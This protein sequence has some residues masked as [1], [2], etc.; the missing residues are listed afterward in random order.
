MPMTPQKAEEL[1][2]Q[3]K[4]SGKSPCDNECLMFMKEYK[5]LTE[6]PAEWTGNRICIKCGKVALQ[7]EFT[8]CGGW[9]LDTLYA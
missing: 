4:A 9:G 7:T 2:S 6:G 8:V 5:N 1:R 3:W